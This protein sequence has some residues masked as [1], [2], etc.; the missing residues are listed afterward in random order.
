MSQLNIRR[1]I[2]GGLA[3]TALAVVCALMTARPVHADPPALGPTIIGIASMD[4]IASGVKEY[5]DLIS[6]FELEKKSI[7]DANAAKQKDLKAIQ[8]SMGILKSDSPDYAKKQ[9]ELLKAS[10]GYDAWAKETQLS[11]DRNRKNKIRNLFNEISDA[12]AQ[13]AVKD[14]LNLVVTDQRPKIPDNLDG[15]DAQQLQQLIGARTILYSDGG[16]DISQKV[17][18]LM[19]KNYL[20]KTAPH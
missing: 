1:P 7:D 6:N 11:F 2:L 9:D 13:V 15:I 18:D 3:V 5:K 4:T 10:I 17:I 12:I 19:D 8:D 20:S 14:G 16:R